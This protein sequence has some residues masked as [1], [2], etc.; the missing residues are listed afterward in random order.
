MNNKEMINV[1]INGDNNLAKNNKQ[2]DNSTNKNK[3]KFK[4]KNK[5]KKKKTKEKKE[6]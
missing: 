6:K 3:I 5:K 4:N 1:S 2:I